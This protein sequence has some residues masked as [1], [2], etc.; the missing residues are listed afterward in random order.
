MMR[1][2]VLT[3]F[4]VLAASNAWELATESSSHQWEAALDVAA[5]ITGIAGMGLTLLKPSWFDERPSTS[6]DILRLRDDP[7]PSAKRGS[8]GS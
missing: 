7:D 5:L 6:V 3:L 8:G 4:A 1:Y 2:L